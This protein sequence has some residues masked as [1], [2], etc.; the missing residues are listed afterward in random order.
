MDLDPLF[1]NLNQN[2]PVH[3]RRIQQRRRAVAI[4]KNT[5]GY[6]EYCK[7]VP[8]EKRKPFSMETPPTPDHTL[9]IP[10]KR[11]QGMVNAWYVHAP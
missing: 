8:K 2:D 10:T 3:A 7:Q 11:W 4:G 6:A 1:S 9:D 5:P